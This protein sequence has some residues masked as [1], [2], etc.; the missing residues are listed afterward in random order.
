MKRIVRGVCGLLS[1]VML[2]SATAMAAEYTPVKA[3]VIP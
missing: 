1:A 2:L 3:K